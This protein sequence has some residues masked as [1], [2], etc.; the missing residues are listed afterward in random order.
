[1][2]GFFL[3]Y[4]Y[5]Y[6]WATLE[7]KVWSCFPIWQ[8]RLKILEHFVRFA[9]RDINTIT[10]FRKSIEVPFCMGF[11]VYLRASKYY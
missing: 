6:T 4:K 7:C 5:L 3:L 1:M 11:G 8:F 10:V 2:N 9:L